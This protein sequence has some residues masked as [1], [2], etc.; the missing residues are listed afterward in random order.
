MEAIT[1]FLQSPWGSA[2]AFGLLTVWPIWR[3]L[4]RAG[5]APAWALLVFV[6]VFGLP[7]ALAVL[8]LRRWPALS[9]KD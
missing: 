8:A 9:A 2:A 6:P 5:F 3:T 4:V 1:E 7:L